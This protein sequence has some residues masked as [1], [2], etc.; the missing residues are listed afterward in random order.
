VPYVAALSEHADPA[1]AVGEAIGQVLDVLGP[2]PDMVMLFVSGAHCGELTNITGAIRHVLRPRAFA[3]TTAVSVVSGGREVE[4]GDGLALWAGKMS[5]WARGVRIDARPTAEGGAVL[6]EL[7]IAGAHTLV[8]LAD[9]YSFP[10]DG[11]ID[12]WHSQYPDLTVLGGLASAAHT[13]KGNQLVVDADIH[14]GGAV[15]ILIGGPTVVEPMV[16]Q[17]CRPIGAPLVITA[18]DANFLVELAGQPALGRLRDIFE[19]L[20]DHD[21]LLVNQ[22]LHIGRVIDEHKMDFGRGD[23]LIRAVMG[24]DE[25]RGA[26][27]IGEP[28]RVGATVQFQVRD[29]SSADEDLRKLIGAGAPADGALLFTCNGRGSHLFAEP[30]HDAILLTEA[31]PGGAVAGMFCAGEIGPVGGRNFVHGFTASAALFRD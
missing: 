10:I 11:A 2:E 29:A 19:R 13:P 7:D 5:G 18:G 31:V 21:K 8:L 22:G 4:E 24:A 3:G 12:L 15:G 25:A 14:D 26:V 1:V 30:D 9:P 17:G 27:V 20:S 6:D 23:F 28:A 16:S